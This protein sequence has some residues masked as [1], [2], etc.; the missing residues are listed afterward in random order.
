MIAFDTIILG[1]PTWSPGSTQYALTMAIS[2]A[3]ALLILGLCLFLALRN[4]GFMR[5][6]QTD[7]PKAFSI[8]SSNWEKLPGTPLKILTPFTK[9]SGI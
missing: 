4:P 9:N 7:L 6:P 5:K 8:A 1:V 3:I 2:A